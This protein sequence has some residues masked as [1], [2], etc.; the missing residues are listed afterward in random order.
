[1][2]DILLD[3]AIKQGSIEGE[4]LIGFMALLGLSL[5]SYYSVAGPEGK[6]Y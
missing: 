4:A 6:P 1:M 3:S 5:E 2:A